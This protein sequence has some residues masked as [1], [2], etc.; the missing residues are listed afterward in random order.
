MGRTISAA[1]KLAKRHAVEGDRQKGAAASRFRPTSG[2]V[3]KQFIAL[4][5]AFSLTTLL[6]LV[7]P[8]C[9]VRCR[10]LAAL[11]RWLA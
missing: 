1:M 6:G 4:F 9:G 8:V 5:M 2:M 10:S 7:Q 3:V 11:G